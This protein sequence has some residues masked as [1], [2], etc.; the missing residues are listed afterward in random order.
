MK[1]GTQQVTATGSNRKRMHILV[2][3]MLKDTAC[4]VMDCDEDAAQD[5]ERW[6]ELIDAGYHIY[7]VRL[8]GFDPAINTAVCDVIVSLRDPVK[9]PDVIELHTLRSKTTGKRHGIQ[10]AQALVKAAD[11]L[12]V[13]L[14]LELA[15]DEAAVRGYNEKALAPL[16]G[17]YNRLGFS[18]SEIPREREWLWGATPA[19]VPTMIR[20]PV[21]LVDR[22]HKKARRRASSC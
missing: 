8:P 2:E 1:S 14:W 3:Q 12:G 18:V 20:P 6:A 11:T 5:D 21:P 9:E 17:F 10:V 19:H 7:Q 13:T 4:E 22:E 16:R 15:P